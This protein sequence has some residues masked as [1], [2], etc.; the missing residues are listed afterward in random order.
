MFKDKLNGINLKWLAGQ[1]GI[2]YMTLYFYIT[3]RRKCPIVIQDKIKDVL[4]K[5]GNT[6][7]NINEV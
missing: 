5:Y 2:P 1:V 3:D 6:L 7:N 4:S